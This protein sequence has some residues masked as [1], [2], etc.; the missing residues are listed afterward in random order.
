MAAIYAYLSSRSNSGSIQTISSK[1]SAG[2]NIALSDDQA[3]TVLFGS[4]TQTHRKL[5]EWQ[6]HRR[7]MQRRRVEPLGGPFGRVFRSRRRGDQRMRIRLLLSIS[8]LVLAAAELVGG[9]YARPALVERR[10]C[11]GSSITATS[12]AKYAPQTEPAL[13]ICG[14]RCG[15]QPP[16]GSGTPELA[17][18][19][20]CHVAVAEP[21]SHTGGRRQN[22]AVITTWEDP[23]CERARSDVPPGRR[24]RV[25]KGAA[26]K[27]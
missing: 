1:R 25:A 22:A 3:G 26:R 27:A 2:E 23:R 15:E 11:L 14:G 17:H 21:R 8:A 24:G 5:L 6:R 19:A 20:G 10:R 16:L 4:G 18:R 12:P 9:T 13:G 7:P